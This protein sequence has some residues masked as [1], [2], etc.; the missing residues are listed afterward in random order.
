MLDQVRSI[1]GVTGASIGLRAIGGLRD[2][3]QGAP[4]EFLAIE[5]EEFLTVAIFRDDYADEPIDQV[6]SAMN[7]SAGPG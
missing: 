7:T 2:G 5:P 4:F 6:L 1:E 3:G